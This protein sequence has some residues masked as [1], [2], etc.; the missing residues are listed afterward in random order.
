VTSGESRCYRV[1]LAVGLGLA[2]LTVAPLQAQPQPQPQTTPS[3]PAFL[4]GAYKE[5]VTNPEA[6]ARGKALYD[7]YG[8]AFCHGPDTRGGNQGPSLLRSQLVQRDQ[9]GETIGPVIRNGVP[10]TTMVGFALEPEQIADI[11]EFLHSFVLDSRDPA[12]QRPASIVTGNPRAGRRYFDAHCA[13]CHSVSEDLRGIA[14]RYPDPVELQT[15]WLMPRNAP[16][17]RV[18]VMAP[19][20]EVTEGRLARIDEFVVSVALDDGTQRSF[21]RAGAVP[22]VEIQDPLAAHKALL[23]RYSDPDIHDVTAYLVTIE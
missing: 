17:T 2:C 15:S 11:A 9:A 7:A 5:R 13:E 10:N 22:Q 18:R 6:V 4:Q 20:G 3:L 23:P 19:D 1:A 12:R 14:A 16:P 8:C 21:A